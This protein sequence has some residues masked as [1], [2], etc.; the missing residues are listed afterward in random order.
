MLTN[1]EEIVVD[2][3]ILLLETKPYATNLI[4]ERALWLAKKLKEVNE[5]CSKVTLE[6][7]EA[8]EALARGVDNGGY[9]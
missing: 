6:L 8:N 7:Q 5:E 4:P 2:V 3:V 9:F 1:E